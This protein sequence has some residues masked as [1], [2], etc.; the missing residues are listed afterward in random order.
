MM[1]ATKAATKVA[2]MIGSK[3]MLGTELRSTFESNGWSVVGP[4]IEELDIRNPDA[5]MQWFSGLIDSSESTPDAVIN[6]A[7]NV[8][9]DRCENNPGGAFVDN[10]MGPKNLAD[11]CIKFRIP[12][13]VQIS[14]DYIFDSANPVRRYAP[15]SEEF[16]PPNV[17]GITK[18]ACEYAVRS[19]YHRAQ[20][21][22][23]QESA[24]GQIPDFLIVRTSRL[25]G[26][27]RWNY[28]DFVCDLCL[29]TS[30]GPEPPRSPQPIDD[31][32]ITVPTSV[33]DISRIILSAVNGNRPGCIINAV[34]GLGRDLQ[35]PSLYDYTEEIY[36]ILK[37]MGKNPYRWFRK[38]DGD[39]LLPASTIR[40]YNSTLCPPDEIGPGIPLPHWK[41]SLKEYIKEKYQ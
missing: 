10:C 4:S 14:T 30:N 6:C 17:Y 18:L 29:S 5:V 11:T 28:V 3:G 9:V 26:K 37:G 19:A 13:F 7:A 2:V 40:P 39:R 27:G 22:W 8:S 1:D 36:E 32:N 38:A 24:T 15:T 23:S 12:L 34:G 16:F 21:K 20:R 33:K 31:T 35:A 25:Y 41:D